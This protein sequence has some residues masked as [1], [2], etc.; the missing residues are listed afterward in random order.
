M[1]KSIF[2]GAVIMVVLLGNF[3]QAGV[4]L[5]KN[6]SFEDDGVINPVTTTQTPHYWYDVSIPSK[7]GGY[8]NTAWSSHG[9]DDG[10]GNSLTLYSRSLAKCNAGDMAA[11][12]QDVY[13]TEDANQIIF[14]L[15]LSSSSGAWD[16]VKRSAVVLIDGA[17]VWD[18]YYWTPDAN[19]EYHNQIVDITD[20]NGV[21]DGNL[22]SLSLAI[23]SNVTETSY[24]YVEYRVRWDFVKFNAHCGGFGYLQGDLNRDC[25]VD[26]NDLRVLAERWL[27][28]A[29][30]EYDFDYEDTVNFHGF[31]NLADNWLDNSD[32]RNWRNDNCYE[33]GLLSLDFDDSGMVDYGDVFVLAENWLNEG[34]GIAADLNGDNKVNFLD[35]AILAGQWRMKSWLYGL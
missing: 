1:E 18:S 34:S 24:P 11:V 20:I 4:S 22:H 26:T 19:K 29:N 2:T 3:V 16:P 12:S 5:V 9:Y 31:A 10:D 25:R 6:G 14:D 15:K 17:A 21:G 28:D 13:L 27:G 33:V 30:D 32:W 35:F 7:F 8:V 23:R